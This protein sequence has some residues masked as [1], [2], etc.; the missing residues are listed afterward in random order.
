MQIQTGLDQ[1]IQRPASMCVCVL[2]AGSKPVATGMFSA[3]GEFVTFLR[4]VHLDRA[5][6][7][8]QW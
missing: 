6:E 2:Q 8:Q 1:Y 7:V 4:P 5:V 3:D